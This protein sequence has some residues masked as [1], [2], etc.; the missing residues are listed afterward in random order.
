M[1]GPLWNPWPPPGPTVKRQVGGQIAQC[2]IGTNDA[3]V[4][5]VQCNGNAVAADPAMLQASTGVA[6]D[7]CKPCGDT[8]SRQLGLGLGAAPAGT[9]PIQAAPHGQTL[10]RSFSETSVQR[11]V[12]G[13]VANPGRA[14]GGRPRVLHISGKHPDVCINGVHVDS[15]HL[16][17]SRVG[18]HRI[19]TRVRDLNESAL[20]TTGDSRVLLVRGSLSVGRKSAK[21]SVA[22]HD[23]VSHWLQE[24]WPVVVYL[25]NDRVLAGGLGDQLKEVASPPPIACCSCSLGSPG[26]P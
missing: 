26:K 16:P 18:A 15:F 3:L 21:I 14:N 1:Q 22:M 17:D 23:M 25:G 6:P 24:M 13:A 7:N 9:S 8:P 10:S 2:I 12:S 20:A 19:K 5:S 4:S 11:R